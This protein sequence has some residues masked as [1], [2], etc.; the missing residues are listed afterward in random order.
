MNYKYYRSR[1]NMKM[2]IKYPD[3]RL[4]IMGKRNNRL[5]EPDMRREISK[6]SESLGSSMNRLNIES[7][8]SS[9]E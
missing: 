4:A 2:M 3:Q 9:V 8:L 7:I 5:N 1:N 6:C